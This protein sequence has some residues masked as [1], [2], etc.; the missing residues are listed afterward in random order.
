MAIAAGALACARV[1]GRAAVRYRIL[2]SAF[3]AAAAAGPAA[4]AGAALR[5]ASSPAAPAIAAVAGRSVIEAA[6]FPLLASGGALAAALLFE[7][8]L[9]VRRL[10]AIKRAA[11]LVGAVPV[12]RARVGTSS[13]VVTPTAI[14]Y[15]HPAIVVPADFR[16]RVDAGEWEAVL[17]HECAHLVRGDDWAKALQSA[18]LR[19]AWWLPGLWMLSRGLDLERELASDERA[20][21]A[22]GSRRYAACL[23]RLATGRC[24]DAVAPGLWGRR[25]HVAIRVERLLRPA[26]AGSPLLRAAALGAFTATALGVLAA[27][28]SVVPG[29]A[30]HV[31]RAAHRVHLAAVPEPRRVRVPHPKP[32]AHRAAAQRPVAA[33]APS[34]LAARRVALAAPAAPPAAAAIRAPLPV[35]RVGPHRRRPAAPARARALLAFP[36]LALGGSRPRCATCFG[37]LR[38]VD[39]PAAGGSSQPVL[40]GSAAVAAE[41]TGSGLPSSASGFVPLQLPRALTPP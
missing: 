23:L 41:D 15:L 9:D 28:V 10:R 33:S 39:T 5:P 11:R 29:I 21:A 13:T 22:T 32:P 38:S 4:L 37:P 25:S 27:A 19:A 17:A 40:G 18:A 7:L 20:A 3:V 16:E 26:G 6:A 8:F 30:R 34:S 24:T 2:A 31:P 14:G 36:A 35:V 1:F 12:R